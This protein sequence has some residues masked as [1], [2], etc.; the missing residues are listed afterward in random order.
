MQ[1]I[2]RADCLLICLAN[3]KMHTLLA[4]MAQLLHAIL[5]KQPGNSLILIF[6]LHP[7]P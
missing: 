5:Q 3:Q 6:R 4:L 7:E 1:F 2:I